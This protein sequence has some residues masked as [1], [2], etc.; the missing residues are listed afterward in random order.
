MKAKTFDSRNSWTG[1]QSLSNFGIPIACQ[2]EKKFL[3]LEEFNGLELLKQKKLAFLP[4]FSNSQPNT[5]FE[6]ELFFSRNGSTWNYGKMTGV[7]QIKKEEVPELRKIL[8]ELPG[9]VRERIS[10]SPEFEICTDAVFAIWKRNFDTNKILEEKHN[11]RFIVN[12]HYKE[13]IIFPAP[14]HV[15]WTR[16][17]RAGK[18]Y[19]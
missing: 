10:N 3:G 13:M 4:A 18:L 19:N 1:P 2:E 5:E 16:N 11:D 14:K 17:R 8:E 6:I 15:E 7:K 12:V 9:I